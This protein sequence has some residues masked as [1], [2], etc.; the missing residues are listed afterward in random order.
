MLL[1]GSLQEAGSIIWNNGTCRGYGRGDD[2]LAPMYMFRRDV[3]YCSAAFLLTRLD[4]FCALGGF[5]AAYRPAYYE[6]TDY[7][8]RLWERGLRVVYEPAAVVL[9]Y[10]FASSPS[11]KEATALHRDHQG[12]FAG[13]HRKK[14]EGHHVPGESQVLRARSARQ[15]SHR[16]LFIDD[17]GPAPC[18][19]RVSP[20]RMGFSR[21]C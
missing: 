20:V 12:L 4:A 5:D 1:D 10:E 15:P 3:D 18:W 13:R 2:P 7:C 19:D 8:M 21:A 14:L 17:R 11:S 6:D 16:V 9:H